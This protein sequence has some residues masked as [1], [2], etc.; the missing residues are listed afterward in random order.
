MNKASASAR[1]SVSGTTGGSALA[2]PMPTSCEHDDGEKLRKP[3][4]EAA[5]PLPAPALAPSLQD[6]VRQCVSPGMARMGHERSLAGEARLEPRLFGEA[7]ARAL[8][9]RREAGAICASPPRSLFS[10]ASH[11][12]RV[13]AH[14]ASAVFNIECYEFP[15]YGV[16]IEVH[17][18]GVIAGKP[19]GLGIMRCGFATRTK[20]SSRQDLKKWDDFSEKPVTAV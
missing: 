12:R 3:R 18:E 17:P 9:S 2:E 19:H 8:L 11:P 10:T 1:K 13:A 20:A 4:H 16:N 14:C 5:A 7:S 6:E 15:R